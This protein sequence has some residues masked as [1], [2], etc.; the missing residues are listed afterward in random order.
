MSV[1]YF[2]ETFK[3]ETGKGFSEYLTELRINE[4]K[5]LLERGD[6]NVREVAA[7]VGYRSANYFS[8]VFHRITGTTPSEYERRTARSG[9]PPEVE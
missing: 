2:S 5:E 7:R 8:R 1:T 6:M 9:N 4:A 3:T